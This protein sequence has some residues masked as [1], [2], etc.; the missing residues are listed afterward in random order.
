MISH[1]Y[2]CQDYVTPTWNCYVCRDV[3]RSRGGPET[4]VQP[5]LTHTGNMWSRETS[6]SNNNMFNALLASLPPLDQPDS[7]QAPA[8]V[9]L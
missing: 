1:H 2:C 4:A 8:V 6:S 9:S 7:S 3:M 5:P